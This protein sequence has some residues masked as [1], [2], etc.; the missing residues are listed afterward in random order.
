MEFQAL[1]GGSLVHLV[2]VDV[3]EH[4]EELMVDQLRQKRKLEKF[5]VFVLPLL[6]EAVDWLLWWLDQRRG[7]V[8]NRR[9]FRGHF[10][11][12]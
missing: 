2:L 8:R 3:L 5:L 12:G 9:V 7:R 10:V 6:R 11:P 4:V 1:L